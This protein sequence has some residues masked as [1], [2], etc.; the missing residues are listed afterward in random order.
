MRNM[1]FVVSGVCPVTVVLLLSAFLVCV[2]AHCVAVP[3]CVYVCGVSVCSGVWSA[4]CVNCV[5]LFFGCEFGVWFCMCCA[6][7]ASVIVI[8][9]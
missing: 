5:R 4:W 9:V 3:V 8:R 1:C 2:C 6:C 7:F